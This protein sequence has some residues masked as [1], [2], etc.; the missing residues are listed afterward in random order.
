[1]TDLPELIPPSVPLEPPQPVPVIEAHQGDEMVKLSEEQKRKTAD[2]ADQFVAAL[3]S[4]DSQ[5][6]GFLLGTKNIHELGQDEIK[7]AANVSSRLMERPMASQKALQEEGG[8]GGGQVADGLVELRRTIESLD[9]TSGISTG[10]KLL[11]FLPIGRKVDD[12]FMR[13]RSAQSHLDAIL[14]T[15]YKGQ[16]ELK[17]DNASI[18]V[19][20]A[21]L[22]ALMGK[23]RE[24]IQLAREVDARLSARLPNIRAKD[25]EMA[26]VVEEE[27]LFAVRQRTTDLL[28]QLAVSVQGYMALDLVRRNNL[29][30]IKGVDRATTTTV[31]ALRTAIVVSQALGTQKLVLDQITALNSTT[32]NMIE[33]TS[34]MLRQQG[35]QIQQQASSST[36]DVAKLQ[37]A[38]D[39]IYGALD[40]VTQYRRRALNSFEQTNRAL[41][42]QIDSSRAY[43]RREERLLEG[44]FTRQLTEEVDVSLKI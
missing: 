37:A 25:P 35:A 6:D 1:M 5:S 9:P 27:L 7:Q 26:R 31:G 28:T 23:L 4:G 19:E 3:L 16:E 44:D 41:E 17:R 14:G 24:Y 2:K 20:K 21:S 40:D 36:V 33:A 13:Y 12:Y 10:R 11:G 38:F 30:L 39:N 43:T 18:E 22:W 32:S 15:L 29:E 42:Q 8:V 34:Q